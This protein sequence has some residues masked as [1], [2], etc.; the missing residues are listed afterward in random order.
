MRVDERPSIYDYVGGEAAFVALAR[1]MTVRCLADPVLNHPFSHETHPDHDQRL[2][3]YL[4]EVFGG[5]ARYSGWGGHSSMLALHAGT[6]ADEDFGL[7]F[8]NCFDLAVEDAGFPDDAEL[9]EVLHGYM[10]WATHEVDE[11]S[12]VGR[13]APEGLAMPRWSWSGPLESRDS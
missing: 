9:R 5:P 13:V 12:P 3:A 10:E 6:G 4:A 7:R 2:G 1:A 8:L 11:Y